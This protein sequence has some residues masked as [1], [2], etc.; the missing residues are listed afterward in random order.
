SARLSPVGSKFSFELLA[1]VE[2]QVVDVPVVRL[3]PK[4]RE[5][6]G[7]DDVRHWKR[8]A[9]H[10]FGNFSRLVQFCAVGASGMLVDLTTYAFFQWVLAR[11][12]LVHETTTFFGFTWPTH[13]ACAG[14]IAVG[15]ALVW[16]FTLNRRL[17][18]N[19]ARTGSIVRQFLTYVLS[20]AVS[21]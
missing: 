15:L 12:V 9:D 8:L 2:G 1:K 6:P 7:W 16:N 11:T 19:D 10:R 20:N 18:F 21:V 17:T 4:R 3:R 13:L 14:V 5:W